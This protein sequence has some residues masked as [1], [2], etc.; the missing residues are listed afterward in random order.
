MEEEKNQNE[1]LKSFQQDL[2]EKTEKAI[3]SVTEQG[4]HDG[5]IDFVFKAIDIHKDITNEEYWKVK[6]ENY[7]RYRGYDRDSYGREEYGNYPAYG[8][9]Y[10]RDSR[11]RFKESGRDSKYRGHEMIDEMY[12]NYD[13]YSEGKEQYIRGNYGAKEDTIKSL[14][15]MMESV[16]CF[17]DMLKKDAS[18]EEMNIIREYSRKIS[19]M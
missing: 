7:M 8:R 5:N 12:G 2:K 18:P 9:G 14:E 15:Y 10:S 13:M 3:K 11:G 1:K 16:A 19:E 4:I 17:V 6:E